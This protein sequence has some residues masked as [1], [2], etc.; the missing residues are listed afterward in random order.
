MQLQLDLQMRV[1]PTQSE[2]WFE[3]REQDAERYESIEQFA[4]QPRSFGRNTMGYAA[5]NVPWGQRAIE[6]R[7]TK[8]ARCCTPGARAH[9]PGNE[10]AQSREVALINGARRVGYIKSR[11][12]PLGKRPI[13]HRR[14]GVP[15][16]L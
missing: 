2:Q 6:G 11:S 8:G 1:F 4:C 10:S 7:P 14:G 15:V 16:T 12:A 3:L 13:V 9:A 5:C